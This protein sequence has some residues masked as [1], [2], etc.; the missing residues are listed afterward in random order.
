MQAQSMP[1]LPDI[2]AYITALE[3][4]VLGQ[5][6]ERVHLGNPFLRRSVTPPLS[7]V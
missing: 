7:M 4:R 1:E 6:L 5:K 2:A 3:T